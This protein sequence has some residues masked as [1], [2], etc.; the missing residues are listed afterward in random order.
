MNTTVDSRNGPTG[1]RDTLILSLACIGSFMVI[2]DATIVSVALPD[3]RTELGFSADALPWV[4]NS[5]TLAF[6]GF[7]LLGGRCGDVFG[8]R[9][10]FLLGVGMFTGAC[11]VAGLVGSPAMLLIAR[12]VQGLGAAL[13]MPVTLALLTTTFTEPDRRARALGI[14]S[15]VGALG[16]A[17]GPVLGGLLTEWLNWRAIFFVNI[18][19]GVGAVAMGLWA[20]PQARGRDDTRLDL[21]GAVLAMSGLVAVVYAVMESS[22]P[23]DITVFGPLVTGCALLALFLLHQARWTQAPLVPPRLLRL[24]TVLS[25]NSVMLLHGLGFF[26]SPI[27]LSLYLQDVMG[28]GP[29]QAGLG[30]L[31][32]G[33]AMFAGA[34]AAGTVTVRWGARR[35]TA[36]CCL[37]GAG[38]FTAV[39]AM[40]GADTPYLLTVGVPGLILGFGSAAAFTPITVAAT[41]GIRDSEQGL[42]AGLLN[43]TRQT[44]GAIGLAVLSTVASSITAQAG[45]SSTPA[46]LA[47]GYSAAF[48]VAGGCLVAAALIA[49]L[50]VP[51]QA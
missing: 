32:V 28:Y 15:A 40:I 9:P 33:I 22:G 45:G 6:A 47:T 49:L 12:V 14:W 50:T 36:V 17:A 16:A 1:Y 13:L 19:L 44:S 41:S 31:P 39:A 25:A 10:V 27:L 35:A 3:I 4:V 51:E 30:Y 20:L 42:A 7:L 2:L 29:L 8:V 5:Y 48:L 11:M 26:A 38:G 23:Q 46:A 18:P 43:T 24:R 37:I 34:R 21:V